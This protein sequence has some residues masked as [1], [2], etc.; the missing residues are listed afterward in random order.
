[1]GFMDSFKGFVDKTK[2]SVANGAKSVSDSS[3]KMAEKSRIKKE[4]TQL[5]SEINNNYFDIGKKYFDAHID[6]T[7]SE[8]AEN[9]A[10]IKANSERLEQFKILLASLDSK[11][12]CKNCGAELNKEQK[13]CDKC[14]SK[15]DPVEVP[16]IEGF[17]DV[18]AV[19]ETAEA[20]PEKAPAET[21]AAEPA[22]PKHCTNC[23]EVLEEGAAFCDKCGTKVE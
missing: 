10:K 13:F 5:E 11:Q 2:E 18:P 7:A 12:V 6:D 14:G 3:K 21:P 15:V 19:P 16:I 9:I 8:Y 23:G 22:A 1:M 20:A 17:N 4:M